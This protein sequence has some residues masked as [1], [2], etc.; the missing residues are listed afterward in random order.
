MTEYTTAATPDPA[1]NALD[2]LV[3]TW[4][5]SGGAEGTVTFRW[6]PG[7]RF[8]VQDIS[9]AQHG[10]DIIGME[11]IGREKPFGAEEPSADVRSRF[12][13]NQGNTF[14]YVYELEGD[15]LTIWAGE[16]GSPA[17]YRGA[18]SADGDTVSGPWT[19][20]GGGGYESTM[21]RIG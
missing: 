3:G 15:T 18:F 20:P 9:L 4:R 11:V 14:D 6:M 10:A 2:R 16:K 1:L 13:D 7:R 5:V 21:T 8:L 12:Y 17:F 19:Y